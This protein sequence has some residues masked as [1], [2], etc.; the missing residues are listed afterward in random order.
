VNVNRKAWLDGDAFDLERVA[1]HLQAENARVAREGEEYYLTSPAIDAAPDDQ[2]ANEVAIKIIAE[3]NA[4]GRMH[5]VNFRPLKLSRYTDDEGQN[6]S[7]GVIGVTLAKVRAHVTATVTRPDGT[8]PQSPPSPWPNYLALAATNKHVARALE[9]MSRTE[10][11]G[12][13]ELYK[14]HEIVRRDVEPDKL[15]AI[16]WT[17]KAQDRAFAAS[18]D[19]YDVSGDAARH[20]VDKRADPL[21]RK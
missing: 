21:R 8:T 10:P 19:R 11:L 6:V 9:I 13:V 2:H 20:A 5:D 18:A 12:W 3:I 1:E 14:V 4:L 15:D 17:T 16:G 7:T